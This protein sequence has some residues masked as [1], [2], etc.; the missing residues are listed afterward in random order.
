MIEAN[1]SGYNVSQ[2][3][4]ILTYVRR[5]IIYSEV[6]SESLGNHGYEVLASTYENGWPFLSN[7]SLI[8][9]GWT[10]YRVAGDAEIST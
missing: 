3:G 5:W 7:S 10:G 6:Y 9:Y 4:H 2:V 8:M 1:S